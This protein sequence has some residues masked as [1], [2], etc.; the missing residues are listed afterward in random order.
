VLQVINGDVRVFIYLLDQRQMNVPTDITTLNIYR[1][2]TMTVKLVR[3][4]WAG[5][6]F[7]SCV[8]K[9]DWRAS[10]PFWGASGPFEGRNTVWVTTPSNRSDPF[11]VL[12]AQIIPHNNSLIQDINECAARLH[13]PS[14]VLSTLVPL[15][16]PRWTFSP[17]IT[18]WGH[19]GT[20][21]CPTLLWVSMSVTF[22][23]SRDV[24]VLNTM[25]PILLGYCALCV[26]GKYPRKQV[27]ECYICGSALQQ[28]LPINPFSVLFSSS[29]RLITVA[30]RYVLSPV[31]VVRR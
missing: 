8:G 13:V 9:R 3:V 17:A 22:T 16:D 1:P 30:A 27:W 20:A 12:S 4:N 26:L 11:N 24:W 29:L 31:S 18:L 15:R 21:R 14:R 5:N 19:F 2:S 10:G 28:F 6:K 25:Q 7:C 23:V